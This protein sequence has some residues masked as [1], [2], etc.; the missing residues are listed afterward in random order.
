[1]CVCVCVCVC[2]RARMCRVGRR[3]G[4]VRGAKRSR[5]HKILENIG[6]DGNESTCNAEDLGSI[7]RSGR[8]PAEGNVY[9]LH[10][11]CLGNP[12]DRGA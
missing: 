6:S 5:D 9:P 7:P 11:S 4:R 3:A 1:M 12:V 10:Y 8:S 2:V